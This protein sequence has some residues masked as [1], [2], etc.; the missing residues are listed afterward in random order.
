ME[1]KN[2]CKCRHCCR[3]PQGPIG[4]QGPQ[5]ERGPKGCTGLQ[6]PKGEQGIQG[7]RGPIGPQG[8]KGEQGIQG[9]RGPIG[10]QGKRGP[11]GEQGPPGKCDCKCKSSGELLENGGME[12]FVGNIPTGWSTTTPNLI[13]RETASGRVHTGESA[14]VMPNGSDLSQIVP[15]QGG[16]FYKLSF[17]AHGE[18]AQVGF[19]ATVT[20]ITGGT[21]LE[22][23]VRRMDMPSGSREFGYYRGITILAPKGATEAEIKFVVTA[24]GNQY[25]DLD[26]VSFFAR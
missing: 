9:E 22:I 12:Q 11:K 10:L 24:N 4:P 8:P 21:G 20:F 17:F 13:S 14:V 6:G 7:E 18:G 25:M 23:T 16:C 26:D 19:T 15:V 1:N 5:G 2:I 3:G